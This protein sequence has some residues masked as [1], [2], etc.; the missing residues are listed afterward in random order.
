M[1]GD[2][3]RLE[4]SWAGIKT[5]VSVIEVAGR[6]H[7]NFSEAHKDVAKVLG[8]EKTLDSPKIRAA[9]S[10]GQVLQEFVYGE[11]PAEIPFR[12]RDLDHSDTNPSKDS[13][14]ILPAIAEH[15]SEKGSDSS[16]SLKDKTPIAS[17][18]KP[19]KFVVKSPADSLA[20]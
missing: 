9:D 6:E 13:L 7:F 10:V 15:E 12:I 2:P 18:A 5:P 3:N 8:S 17:E 4:D 20:A 14:K 1:L 11:T 19:K 16:I